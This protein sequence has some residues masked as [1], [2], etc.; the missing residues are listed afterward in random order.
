MKKSLKAALLSG[1]MFPGSGHFM[2]KSRLRG[3]ALS[4]ISL[5]GVAFLVNDAMQKAFAMVDSIQSGAISIANNQAI[6]QLMT[7][8]SVGADSMMVKWVTW[9]VMGAWIFGIVDAYRLGQKV[10]QAESKTQ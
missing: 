10:D 1:F 7:Q 3:F 2:L 9:L 5:A 6:Q 4:G 8:S